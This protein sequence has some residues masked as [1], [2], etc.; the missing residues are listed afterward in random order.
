MERTQEG[1]WEN[2]VLM[3][4]LSFITFTFCCVSVVSI[5]ESLY[6][7]TGAISKLQIVLL[8]LS[9][10]RICFPNFISRFCQLN[11]ELQTCVHVIKSLF[12]FF[13]EKLF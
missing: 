7:Y 8:T 5:C 11:I 9:L 6:V 12:I 4:L 2:T 13:I 1:I 3:V 10:K